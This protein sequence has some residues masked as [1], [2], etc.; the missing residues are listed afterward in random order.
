MPGLVLTTS[1]LPPLGASCL[2]AVNASAPPARLSEEICETALDG[3]FSVVST[4]TT[5]MPAATAW[6]IGVWLADTSSGAI[7]SASGFDDVTE[8]MIG[9]CS[10]ASN[11]V[12][13]WMLTLMLPI[14]FASALMP[15]PIVT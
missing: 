13:P 6:S 10:V 11:W 1:T 15:Q 4:S 8:A 2:I 9:F 5:L 12:G 14:F 7:S 3:S